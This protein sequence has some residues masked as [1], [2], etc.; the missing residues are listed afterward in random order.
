MPFFRFVVP[1]ED[2]RAM[3]WAGSSWNGPGQFELPGE[4]AV[5][6]FKIPNN[7]ESGF[8]ELLGVICHEIKLPVFSCA[9]GLCQDLFGIESAGEIK[10]YFCCVPGREDHVL[11]SIREGMRNSRC[12]Y[13][14]DI[15]PQ[16]GICLGLIGEKAGIGFGYNSKG[17]LRGA[18]LAL[19][20]HE[21]FKKGSPRMAYGGDLHR[22]H[23]AI[24]LAPVVECPRHDPQPEPIPRVLLKPR[25]PLGRPRSAAHRDKPAQPLIESA[26]T[27]AVAD[28]WELQGR[29]QERLRSQ[30]R[31]FEVDAL[32]TRVV[33]DLLQRPESS[34]AKHLSRRWQDIQLGEPVRSFAEWAVKVKADILKLPVNLKREDSSC[35]CSSDSVSDQRSVASSSL[36]SR[37][38]RSDPSS[39]RRSRSRTPRRSRA[40]KGW[41]RG[42]E[43]PKSPP[44]TRV[45]KLRDTSTILPTSPLASPL[46][47]RAESPD[48]ATGD[49]SSGG[50]EDESG[51]GED[52]S[53]DE[54]E[55]VG[56]KA[57]KMSMNL[58]ERPT[59]DQVLKIYAKLR[60]QVEKSKVK[61][62][63][64]F[65][66]A[67]VATEEEGA[68]PMNQ[69]LAWKLQKGAPQY[70][71]A[72]YPRALENQRHL[73][74][75]I[76]IS[77]LKLCHSDISPVFL[78]HP[79]RGRPVEGLIKALE[80]GTANSLDITPL[81][82]MLLNGEYWTV[83][84]NRRLYAYKEFQKKTTMIVKTRAIVYDLA[85]SEQV[86]P[87]LIAKFLTASTTETHGQ[88]VKMRQPQQWR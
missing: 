54:V 80:D 4:D 1:K 58:N 61:E 39:S 72:I 5:F 13:L 30:V 14:K 65:D 62:E 86:P 7:S 18:A 11:K 43:I 53:E 88:T 33:K 40:E 17:L 51:S 12:R 83:M 75:T 59:P 56:I 47:V 38:R 21:T 3:A 34:S 55:L 48:L 81:V 84:G 8:V 27:V 24:I 2:A 66:Q 79:H 10:Q 68:R 26:A 70:D 49:S 74:I 28:R 19:A 78:Q 20:L 63:L 87:C 22:W 45:V 73:L 36:R 71:P 85:D 57:G 6:R 41:S 50:S 46:S 25:H 64:D 15:E 44:P 69:I 82:V 60:E 29:V 77:R 23:Q 76:P 16:L 42:R 32:T 67:S 37:S 52:S 35:S 9:V 31:H